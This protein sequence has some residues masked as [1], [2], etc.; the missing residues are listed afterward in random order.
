MRK[1]VNEKVEEKDVHGR[2]ECRINTQ[3]F[4]D[5]IHIHLIVVVHTVYPPTSRRFK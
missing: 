5:Q 1:K 2:R 3:T 4:I